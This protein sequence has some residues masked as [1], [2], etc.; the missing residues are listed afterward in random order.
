MWFGAA[1][2]EGVYSVLHRSEGVA[3]EGAGCKADAGSVV[4]VD[5]RVGYYG[6][7]SVWDEFVAPDESEYKLD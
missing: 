5:L 2:A 3:G 4:V 1:G 7:C 6:G